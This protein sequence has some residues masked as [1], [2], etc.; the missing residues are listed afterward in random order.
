MVDA[1]LLKLI[2]G[3][4]HRPPWLAVMWCVTRLGA[5]EIALP[6]AAVLLMESLIRR[7]PRALSWLGIPLAAAVVEGLKIVVHRPRPWAVDPMFG[8]PPA[9]VTLSFPSGHAAMAFALATALSLRWPK[10]RAGWF[11]V[12]TLV[13]LS[14][15]AL[16]LHWPT[17]VAAG[18]LIG[19]GVVRAAARIEQ[20]VR[21]R[22]AGPAATR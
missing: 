18:A 7:K 13:A 4:L 22:A 3:W 5:T 2:Y 17:D 9:H 12:A 6:L 20:A 16:G 21:R 11:G 15:L 14:R 1:A 10:G 8:P 19:W